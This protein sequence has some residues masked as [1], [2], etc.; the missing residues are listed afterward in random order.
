M[1]PAPPSSVEPSPVPSSMGSRRCRPLLGRRAVAAVV[2]LLAGAQAGC[3]LTEQ[4]LAPSEDVVVVEGVVQLREERG[5]R[6]Q[7]VIVFL[8][9]TVSGDRPIDVPGATVTVTKPDGEVLRIPESIQGE[10]AAATPDVDR[11]GTCYS[12]RDDETLDLSPGDRLE[13]SVRTAAGEEMR[14]ATTIPGEHTILATNQRFCWIYPDSQLEVVWSSSSGAWAYFAEALISGLDDALRSEGI[15]VEGDPIYLTGV[16]VS[17]ADTAIGFPAEFGV[18]DRGSIDTDLAVRLQRGLPDG[19][20]SDV[21]ITAVDRNATNWIRGGN[22]NPSGQVRIPSIRGEGTG[23]FGSSVV[24]SF[25]VFSIDL[26]SSS[27]RCRGAGPD[28]R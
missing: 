8:H 1:Y 7:R 21:A 5:E 14:A 25:K 6:D 16:S 19:V 9:R 2:L 13:L 17:A 12:L 23:Y 26:A 20:S 18:F 15:E 10:C 11:P 4:V 24:R 27:T 22:F 3:E 28:P